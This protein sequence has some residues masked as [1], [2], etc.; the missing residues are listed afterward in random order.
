MSRIVKL[1][2]NPN[3]AVI[4]EKNA[5]YRIDDCAEVQVYCSRFGFHNGFSFSIQYIDNHSRFDIVDV[6]AFKKTTV[7]WLTSNKLFVYAALRVAEHM[8]YSL[9]DAEED[10]VIHS[11]WKFIDLERIRHFQQFYEEKKQGLTVSLQSIVNDEVEE[12]EDQV[13]DE[14][15]LKWLEKYNPEYVKAF[16]NASLHQS[17]VREHYRKPFLFFRVPFKG[18]VYEVVV[19]LYGHS[20]EDDTSQGETTWAC[21]YVRNFGETVVRP[22]YILSAGFV[23]LHRIH[24][25]T[26][27][28]TT[29]EDDVV[30]VIM[31]K[32][33]KE[34]GFGKLEQYHTDPFSLDER[35]H[36]LWSEGTTPLSQDEIRWEAKQKRDAENVARRARMAAVKEK[37]IQGI[38]VE[39]DDQERDDIE[40]EKKEEERVTSKEKYRKSMQ[41]FVDSWNKERKKQ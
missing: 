21:F 24:M 33:G 22:K 35:H 16:R 27:Y 37:R 31:E 32:F 40:A 30:S 25:C 20:T 14:E 3:L 9:E 4:H 36:Y 13:V 19:V 34:Y 10:K 2:H 15:D 41:E 8:G 7:K 1:P 6:N 12:E 11:Q 38:V 29:D 18:H 17:A 28:G 23:P 26:F 39:E 5:V